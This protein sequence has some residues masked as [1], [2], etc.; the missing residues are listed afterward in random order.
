MSFLYVPFWR[1]GGYEQIQYRTQLYLAPLS[2][3]PVQL[4]V[5][6]FENGGRPWVGKKF[7]V[8]IDQQVGEV[9]TDNSGMVAIR[10][11]PNQV[12]RIEIN[13]LNHE[14]GTAEVH[15][16]DGEPSVALL[17]RGDLEVFASET[18]S[19]GFE[20]STSEITITGCRPV[21]LELGQ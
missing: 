15:L 2:Q 16:L 9:V 7:S 8:E 18:N 14:Y 21:T 3:A 10:L 12:A 4:G 19:P 20:M 11:G 6:F 5:Y 1:A 17:A 13:V